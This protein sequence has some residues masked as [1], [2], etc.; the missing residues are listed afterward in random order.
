MF[1]GD[2]AGNTSR[3][4]SAGQYQGYFGG[5]TSELGLRRYIYMLTFGFT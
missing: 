4:T 3:R 1:R 5:P 2:D